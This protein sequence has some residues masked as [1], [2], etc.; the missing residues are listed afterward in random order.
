ML[1]AIIEHNGNTLLL[2]FPCKRM[3]LA[4]H[5][6]S[7]GIRTAPHEIKCIDEED[8]PIQVNIYG[9]SE[10]DSKLAL[11]TEKASLTANSLLL[12]LL[13]IQSREST[14]GAISITTCHTQISRRFSLQC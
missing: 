4:E 8:A 2:E 7:S 11:S 3:L 6:A 9:E 10:F 13:R 14:D 12:F 5:L 1:K